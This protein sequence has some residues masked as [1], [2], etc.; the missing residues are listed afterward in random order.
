MNSQ[1][2]CPN[3]SSPLVAAFLGVGN[4]TAYTGLV[5]GRLPA[6]GAAKFRHS[7]SGV[8]EGGVDIFL[9]FLSLLF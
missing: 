8:G 3:R 1:G 2:N 9:I 6:V 5:F 4:M 7:S